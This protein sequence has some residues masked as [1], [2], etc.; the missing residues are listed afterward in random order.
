MDYFGCASA[1]DELLEKRGLY[2]NHAHAK[3]YHETYARGH[4]APHFPM[5][6][7]TYEVVYYYLVIR[8]FDCKGD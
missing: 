7:I 8:Y 4:I 6:A 5:P 3:V 2:L 1:L